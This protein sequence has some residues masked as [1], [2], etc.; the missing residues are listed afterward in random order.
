[1]SLRRV[2]YSP[3]VSTQQP[4]SIST[5]P[6]ISFSPSL[7]LSPSV[8]PPT[9]NSS[10]EV[11][12]VGVIAFSVFGFVLAGVLI[13]CYLTGFLK[14]ICA[15]HITKNESES[16]T[17]EKSSGKR[18]SVNRFIIINPSF[19]DIEN[20]TAQ[21]QSQKHLLNSTKDGQVI[22]SSF[23]M[24]SIY[25]GDDNQIDTPNLTPCGS[26]S[27]ASSGDRLSYNGRASGEGALSHG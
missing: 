4:V 18:E 12:N 11:L 21:H 22:R 1:M 9:K 3:T 5:R 13:F 6:V 7:S 25:V 10:S 20:A 8:A 16:Q 26:P 15:R 24:E 19:G 17:V 2:S 23:G 27:K 14:Y